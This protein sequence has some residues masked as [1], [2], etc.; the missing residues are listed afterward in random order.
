M[1]SQRMPLQTP[2]YKTRA[3]VVI[4]PR[5][6]HNGLRLLVDGASGAGKTSYLRYLI[7]SLVSSYDVMVAYVPQ[8]PALFPATVSEN[9]SFFSEYSD[10]EQREALGAMALDHISPSTLI[11][12]NG[13][14]LSG[15]EQQRLCLA[16]AYLH[17]ERCA[18]MVLDE[19]FAGLD[20]VTAS[21]IF[22]KLSDVAIPMIYT[23]HTKELKRLA[24]S[25]VTL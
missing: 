19:P 18:V 13:F 10:S 8:A 6:M 20:L 1:W 7:D 2:E 5:E 9:V 14:P 25:S 16:R 24:T 23:T 17:R 21:E 12:A 22:T 15:G 11:K 3:G 4:P